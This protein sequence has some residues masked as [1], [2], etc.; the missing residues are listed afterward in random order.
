MAENMSVCLSARVCCAMALHTRSFSKQHVLRPR[1]H[2]G[3]GQ[4]SDCCCLCMH[5]SIVKADGCVALE[6]MAVGETC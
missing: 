6:Q 1:G 3:G 5:V 4:A 2:G